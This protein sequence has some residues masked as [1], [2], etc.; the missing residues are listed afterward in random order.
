MTV[1]QLA[2]ASGVA[3]SNI[4]AIE[5]GK[6]PASK[7]M[8]QRLLDATGRPSAVLGRRKSEVVSTITRLGGSNPRLFG[9]VARGEDTVGSDIDLLIRVEPGRVWEFVTLPRVLSELLEV[10]VEV[11]DEA[12]LHGVV[13]QRILAEAV[14]L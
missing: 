13:G 1:A 2:R 7:A 9:S 4:S 14:P 12:G 3:A 8:T 6:R 10:D 11:V 5:A